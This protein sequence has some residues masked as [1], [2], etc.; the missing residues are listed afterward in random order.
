[1]LRIDS[2]QLNSIKPC[3]QLCCVRYKNSVHYLFFHLVPKIQLNNTHLCL[4]LLRLLMLILVFP[5]PS[6]PLTMCSFTFLQLVNIFCGGYGKTTTVLATCTIWG[7]YFFLPTL[8]LMH[9]S[10]CI[11]TALILWIC[12]FSFVLH[13]TLYSMARLYNYWICFFC[14]LINGYWPI[15][16][17]IESA[18]LL[19]SF[20]SMPGHIIV[21]LSTSSS[22][23]D[24]CLSHLW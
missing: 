19:F 15:M 2:I 9:L 16:L 10:I 17:L 13:F 14:F 21:V 4:Y 3:P 7:M 5:L 11:S 24:V 6:I 22:F 8:I 23:I 18:H 12:Y 20:Y 1:M